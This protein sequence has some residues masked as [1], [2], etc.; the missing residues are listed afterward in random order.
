MDSHAT[1]LLLVHVVAVILAAVMV[2]TLS[3]LGAERVEPPS[4]EERQPKRHELLQDPFSV[5]EQIK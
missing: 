5:N 2:C 1:F 4:K 3:L